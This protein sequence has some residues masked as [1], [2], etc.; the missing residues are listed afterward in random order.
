MFINKFN[1]LPSEWDAGFFNL[2]DLEKYIDQHK[3]HIIATHYNMAK[4]I[5]NSLLYLGGSSCIYVL[6]YNRTYYLN[7]KEK[8]GVCLVFKNKTKKVE[9]L[10]DF[11]IKLIIPEK[12]ATGSLNILVSI[13]G[14]FGLEQKKIECPDIDFE[15]NYNDN[16]KEINNLILEK[17]AIENSKGLILLHGKAG[18]GKTTYIRYLINQ[19]NKQIIYIPPA[20]ANAIADP[21]FIKFLIS[22]CTNSILI[23]EDAEN[24]LMKRVAG[25]S[26]AISNILNLSDGLLSDCLNIQIIATF[27]TDSLNIAPA[28][29]RKGRLIAKYEFTELSE[30]KSIKLGKK[31]GVDITGKNTLA[32][33]YNK[34]EMSFLQEKD[35]IGFLK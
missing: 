15:L 8:F 33:I 2:K 14:G 18:T 13:G 21:F 27:N 24:V 1:C 10:M 11:F 16:F 17:L 9:E 7:D 30:E 31:I 19:L 35:I 34:K 20:I 32:N 3:K 28:L 25:S 6:V 29:L 4:S 12:E 22:H 5:K 26:Q 23:I